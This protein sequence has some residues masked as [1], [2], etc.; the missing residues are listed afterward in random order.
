MG[1]VKAVKT[2]FRKYATFTGRASRSEYWW[3]CG[4][5]VVGVI[6]CQFIDGPFFNATIF[7]IPQEFIP[8]TEFFLLLTLLPSISVAARRLQDTGLNGRPWVIAMFFVEAINYW[9]TYVE[10]TDAPVSVEDKDPYFLVFIGW[11][12]FEVIV[13]ILAIRPS[14]PGTNKFGSN[15]HE[16]SS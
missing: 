5:I 14:Q 8:T 4:F 6:A 15:P 10:L 16:V 7:A 1:P 13:L 12:I 11:A 9:L 2:C 3:F